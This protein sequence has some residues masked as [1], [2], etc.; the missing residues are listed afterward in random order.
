MFILNLI[1]RIREWKSFVMLPAFL[2]LVVWFK[3][4]FKSVKVYF[5]N[6]SMD[7]EIKLQGL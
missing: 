1:Y 3:F 6:L 4:A 7:C 2:S 5:S